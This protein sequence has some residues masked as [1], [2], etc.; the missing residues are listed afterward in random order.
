MA[1]DIVAGESDELDLP[2]DELLG[3]GLDPAQLGGAHGRVVGRVREEARP[4]ILD[5]VVEGQR[6]CKRL[7]KSYCFGLLT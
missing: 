5:E 6:A 7:T 3:E 4:A 2:V 1:L